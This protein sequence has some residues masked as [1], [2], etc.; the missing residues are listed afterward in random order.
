M[1]W[2]KQMFTRRHRYDELSESIREHVDEKIA[3][4]MDRGMTQEQAESTA[5]REF[6]NVTRIEER[7]R[8]VWQWPSIENLLHDLRFSIR[9]LRRNPGFTAV[10]L[11]SLSLGV[12]ATSTIFSAMYGVIVAPPLYRNARRLVVLWE[13]NKTTGQLRT[14]V[15]PATFRDWLESAHS[16]DGLELVAA[17]S[18]VTVTGSG[19][20]ER[21]NIQYAT[22]G[23]FTLLGI[24][25]AS[26]RSFTEE[27]GR[28]GGAVVIS[29]D[30]WSGH[31]ARDPSAIGQP[32]TVNGSAQTVI[33]VLPESFHLFDRNTDLWMPIE[34]PAANSQDRT[35]RSWLIAVGRLRPGT[36][37]ASAQR[38]MDYLSDRIAK[39]HPN[40]NRNW[41]VIV[42]PIQDAQFQYWDHI[43]YLLLG[44]VGLVLLI[45][46]ANVANLLLG[47]FTTRSR[48]LCLRASLGASRSRI[49]R[50]LLTEGLFLGIAGSLLAWPLTWLGLRLFRAL[51]PV[52]FPLLESVRINLPVLMFSLAISLLS[53]IAATVGP[54]LGASRFRAINILRSNTS[55]TL[56]RT[57]SAYRNVL[58]VAEIALS[59]VLLSG[60]G[61]MVNSLLRLLRVDP[62]FTSDHILT[63]EMFLAGPKYFQ[64]GPS[65][66]QIH[67]SVED[68]Y[69]RL[70][71]QAG[72]I[73]GVESAGLVSWLPEMGYNTGRR[74]RGF[75]IPGQGQDDRSK[76]PV[77][78]FNSVSP[79]YFK[80]LGIP[81][82]RGRVFELNEN[83][84]TPQVAII[85][86]AFMLEYF[87][88][89]DPIG[90]PIVVDD[91]VTKVSRQVVGIV[92][93]V[94]QNSLD[95]TPVPEIFVPYT[96]QRDITPAYGYQNRVHMT[97]V[98][99]TVAEPA[100]V[101]SSLR[102]IAAEMDSSQPIYGVRSMS[103]V[104]SES[105]S[106]QR[107]CTNLLELIAGIALFLS[108]IGIYGV[109]SHAVLQRTNEIG[110]RMAVGATVKDILRLVF[111]QSGKIAVAGVA[112]GL[113]LAL[114][115][116]RFLSSYLF[117]INA[118]DPAT[119]VV[120]CSV[121]LLVSAG[122]VWIPARRAASVDPMQALRSE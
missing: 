117:E 12:A 59:L 122:A 84:N 30:F 6:G 50:Q 7:S 95:E 108:A 71:Q 111:F 44:I 15:A 60:T 107:L 24:Q 41:G 80:T 99:R 75:Q 91:G 10:I 73:P 85:N 49:A 116:D 18:P 94:R 121:L 77:A 82:L 106:L 98:L 20:P 67:K 25:L 3:D 81:L 53:G 112:I 55:N 86:R 57:H 68:F 32:I 29:Y 21:A 40:T 87:S 93:D 65:G 96:Q 2:L 78:A 13:S 38:E 4:L 48:E 102:R 37:L 5:R 100:T 103:E 64:F 109:M 70:I 9:M 89:T 11:L 90:K 120:C 114:V 52:D 92:G 72:A 74:E 119:I 61:L 56:G 97:I 63:M 113:A 101:V 51:A 34:R 22:P 16:F 23:L 42:D 33:G 28:T 76:Q 105:T 31:F 47:R 69:S 66:V 88:R 115:F 1:S 39:A 104:V 36:T 17:G 14:P 79:D 27:E 83:G 8:E 35:F 110:L 43:L 46:C 54:A 45:S 118:T 58:V 26:G 19:L 62:G